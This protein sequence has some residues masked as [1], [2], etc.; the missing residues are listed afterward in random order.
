MGSSS[1]PA[2]ALTAVKVVLVQSSGFSSDPIPSGSLSTP[3]DHNGPSLTVVTEDVG[4][5]Q[6]QIALFNGNRMKLVSSEPLPGRKPGTIVTGWRYTWS[7]QGSFAN[8]TFTYQST[9]INF[10][11][12]TL[13]T[14]LFIR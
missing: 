10:P 9:S 5:G 8:G 13:S 1:A 6:S 7:Y 12:R 14:R 2:P 3:N 4:Y 11:V